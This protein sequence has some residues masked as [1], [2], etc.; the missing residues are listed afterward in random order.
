M[1][2][3]Y[4]NDLILCSHRNGI[5]LLKTNIYLQNLIRGNFR[6]FADDGVSLTCQ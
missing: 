1:N 2:K 3:C 6:Y 4:E 5:Q